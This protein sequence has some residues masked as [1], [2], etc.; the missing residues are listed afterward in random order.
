MA[1]QI[2]EKLL[3]PAAKEALRNAK[4][5]SKLLRDALEAYVRLDVTN[6]DILNHLSSNV[7]E[8][9]GMVLKLLE[10]ENNFI[11]GSVSVTVERSKNEIAAASEQPKPAKN[12]SISEEEKKRIEEIYDSSLRFFGEGD[13][14]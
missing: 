2:D 8:I 9:K 12:D 14:D 13:D 5:K 4:S 11:D 3:S 1:I 10:K 6:L 7:S